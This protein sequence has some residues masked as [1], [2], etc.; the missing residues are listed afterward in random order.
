MVDAESSSM[1]F[2]CQQGVGNQRH[3]RVVSHADTRVPSVQNPTECPPLEDNAQAGPPASDS[4]RKQYPKREGTPPGEDG[5]PSKKA[6]AGGKLHKGDV[7]K[8][9]LSFGD[10]LDEDE[11]ADGDGGSFSLAATT[12]R[13]CGPSPS[14]P[15]LCP[16]FLLRSSTSRSVAP[17]S[18]AQPPP[19]CLGEDLDLS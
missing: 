9:M 1:A 7:A 8:N 12:A 3:S 2:L 11:L 14:V 16:A 13:R 4:P 18:R 17:L 5:P 19:R 6:R 15:P 10:E